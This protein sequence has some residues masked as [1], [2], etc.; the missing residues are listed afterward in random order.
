MIVRPALISALFVFVACASAPP[1]QK[2]PA[3][4]PTSS[5]P[6]PPAGPTRTDVKQIS[7][8]L[9]QRCIAGGWISRWRSTN[10][11]VDAARPKIYLRDFADQTGQNLDPSYLTSE[12]LRRMRTS[13]VFEMVG[14]GTDYDFEGRGKLLRLAERGKGGARI[15]VYTA[16]LEL[17]SPKDSK[18]AY[19]CEATVQGD[20]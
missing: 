9:V 6:P 19:S 18:V 10:P 15:S 8:E 5:A 2:A 14:E 3:E 11:D 7:A 4:R 17:V 13:G 20:M 16:V 12:L 1:P